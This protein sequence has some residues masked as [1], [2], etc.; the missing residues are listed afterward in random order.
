MTILVSLLSQNSGSRH[1]ISR[2]EVKTSTS[3]SPKPP[4][5]INWVL[6]DP[7]GF[8]WNPFMGESM[9]PEPVKLQWANMFMQSMS[10]KFC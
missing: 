4:V 10:D 7:G 5:K 3:E 6:A 1:K 8:A 2:E 9:V